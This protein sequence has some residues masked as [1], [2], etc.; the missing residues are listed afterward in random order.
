ASPVGSYPIT[1]AKG[2]LDATNYQFAF[3]NGTLAVNKASTATAA[4]VSVLTPLFGV[5]GVT[6]T[7]AISV[8]A[9]GSGSPSGTVT[10]REG[11]T[12]LG[13]ASIVNGAATLALGSTDLA[14]GAH[15]IV[16]E[17]GGD[18]QFTGSISPAATVTVLAPSTVQG[19]VYVDSD[20]DGQVDFGETA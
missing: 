5:D 1:A 19:L 8:V 15:A 16:A 12:V 9:P 4:A 3:V 14:V 2:T 17:Y 10:F 18:S 6:L 11:T 7:A 20:D 13:T